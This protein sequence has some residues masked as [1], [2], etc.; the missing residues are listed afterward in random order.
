MSHLKQFQPPAFLRGIEKSMIRKISD[1]ARPG[2]I[3]LGLG[4]P[5]LP[6]PEVIRR[7]GARVIAEE[8]NGYTLQAGL[9]ALRERVAGDYPHMNLSLDQLVITAGSAENPLAEQFGNHGGIAG[10]SLPGVDDLDR[11]GR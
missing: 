7:E 11:G 4:E 8:Q 5:D 2:S 1:R 3:S 9:P 10:S 6:T